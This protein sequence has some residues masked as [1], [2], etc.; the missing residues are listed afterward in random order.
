MDNKRIKI[1]LASSNELTEDR[2]M[3]GNFVRRLDKIYSKRELHLDLFE[4][5]EYDASYNGLRRQD[6]YNNAI[7]QSDYFIALLHTKIGEFTTKELQVAMGDFYVKGH[8]IVYVFCKTVSTT[9]R[10]TPE[11]KAFKENLSK[12]G[13][14]WINYSNQDQLQ[15]Y[16]IQQLLIAENNLGELKLAGNT[17]TLND[18]SI[19]NIDNLAFA[20]ENKDYQRISAELFTLPG[21]IDGARQFVDE[22]PDNGYMHGELQKKLDRY[23]ALKEEFARLQETLFETSQRIATIQHEQLSDKLRHATEAFD[24][25]NT[26]RANTLLDEI[27]NEAETHYEDLSQDSAFVHQGIEAFLLQAKSVMADINTPIKERIKQVEEIYAKADKWGKSCALPNEKYERLLDDYAHFLFDYGM[28]EK[29]EYIFLR[30]INICEELYGTEHPNTANVYNNIGSVYK[31]Q[32]NFPKALEYY[33]KAMSIREHVLGVDHPDTATSYNDIG[34]IYY[35]QGNYSKA[36]KF[37]SKAL[38]IREQVLGSNHPNTAM[39]LINIGEIYNIQGDY[40]KALKYYG[41]ALDI[42]ERVLGPDHPDTATSYNNIGAVY[43]SQ[44]DY[45]KALEFYGKALG[46]Q[47]RVLGPDHPLTVGSYNNIGIVYKKQGDYAK[48]LEYYRKALD[49][50][51]RVLGPDH[52]D[53][54]TSYN[55]IGFVYYEQGNY[56]MALEYHG[57]ALDIR[58]RVLGPDHPLTATSYDNIGLVYDDQGNYAKALEYFGKV[59]DIRERVLGPD[60]P[61]TATSYN[62]IGFVYYEQGK[63]AEALEYLEKALDIFKR[64]LGS[65]HPNTKTIRYNIEDIIHRFN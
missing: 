56:A 34:C 25:G 8:P 5:E 29:A 36:L 22:H 27:A 57:K 9:E 63:Y 7:R 18:V 10:E 6:E 37:Y 55:N 4:W 45:A 52:P 30:L 32:G 16:F 46:I 60:H 17:I 42:K 26:E 59:L 15:L 3:F 24:S 62:N 54:A 39:S 44:G 51:E 41:K 28:Y 23:N 2:I 1:F 21:E 12:N 38:S 48:A 13:S 20:K 64:K 19:A 47:E 31:C 14:F 61:L 65:D 53:T 50:N 33:E 11:L 35:D 43:D 40:P 58:E 49:I